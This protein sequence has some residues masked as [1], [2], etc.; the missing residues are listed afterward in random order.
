MKILG[1][2]IMLIGTITVMVGLIRFIIAAFNEGALWGIG[3]LVFPLIA[4]VYL[5]VHWIDGWRPAL[6]AAVGYGI[7]I[8]GFYLKTGTVF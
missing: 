5:I 2:V 4:L 1:T 3:S 8:L 6:T 7:V